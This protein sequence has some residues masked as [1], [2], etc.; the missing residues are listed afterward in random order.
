[1]LERGII[2]EGRKLQSKNE[3]QEQ[4]LQLSEGVVL[5][6]LSGEPTF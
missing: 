5:N 2:L 4:I 3:F 6:F 1:M